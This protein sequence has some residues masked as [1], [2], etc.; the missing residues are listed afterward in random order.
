[1][2]GDNSTKLLLALLVIY[3]VVYYLTQ[4]RIVAA[5]ER[6]V[7]LAKSEAQR[8]AEA[9]SRMAE[10]MRREWIARREEARERL[11]AIKRLEAKRSSL[12][13]GFTAMPFATS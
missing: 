10:Q 4:V 1:M 11:D 7:S 13:A 8:W 5:L 6:A 2:R 9:E 12:T 3:A